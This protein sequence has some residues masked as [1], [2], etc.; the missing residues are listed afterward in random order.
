MA[1][2][3]F[4]QPPN[5]FKETPKKNVQECKSNK[6]VTERLKEVTNEQCYDLV[7]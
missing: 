5:R 7:A 1:R 3:G 2:F 4:S 6:N